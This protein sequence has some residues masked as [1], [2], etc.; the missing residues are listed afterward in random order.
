MSPSFGIASDALIR[1]GTR[2][3]IN[4]LRPNS[5]SLTRG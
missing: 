5:A 4:L 3:H 2:C 1:T